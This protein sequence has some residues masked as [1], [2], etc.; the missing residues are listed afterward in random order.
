M[1]VRKSEIIGLLSL[2]VLGVVGCAASYQ[3]ELR[4]WMDQERRSV[5][6]KVTPISEPKQFVAAK[7]KESEAADPFN[8][9]RLTVALQKDKAQNAGALLIA[10]EE[11]R[12]KEPLENYPLDTIV[13]VGSLTKGGRIVGLVKVD[14][15]LYQVVPGNH[16]G[17]DYGKIMAIDEGQSTLREIVQDSLGEWIE[18][19]TVM[20]LQESD[21]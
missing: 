20:Q 4:Q 18:K 15:L 14:N 7:Y 9:S 11:K 8:M 21:K 16:L 10:A 19:I 17:Q 1:I 2:C 6:P 3:E 5:V 13:M 12:A